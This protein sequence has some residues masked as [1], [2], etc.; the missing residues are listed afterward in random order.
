MG[1]SARSAGLMLV[2]ALLIQFAAC[3]DASSSGTQ[4]R[5]STGSEGQREEKFLSLFSI[6]RFPNTLCVASN[7]YNGTCLTTA[8][9]SAKGGTASGTCA[10]GFGVCCVL[11][12]QTC[13][14]TTSLNN[15]Y[16]QNNG[17]SS[18]YTTAGQCSLFVSRASSDVDQLRLEFLT[19]TLA[20]PDSATLSTTGQCITDSFTVSGAANIVPAIC[21]A[22][23][24]QHMYIN[25]GPGTSTVTLSIITS[26]TSTS[27]YWNIRVIQSSENDFMESIESLMQLG[28]DGNTRNKKGWNAL[29]LLCFYNSSQHLTAAIKLLIKS[30]I[31]KDAKEKDGWN[32][33]HLLCFNNSSPGLIEAINLLINP[34]NDINATT[35]GGSNA[36]HLL[37]YNNSSRNL[38]NAIKLLIE[39]GIDINAKK[40]DGC[41][42][43]HLLCYNNLSPG[44]ID[45]IK[46]LFDQGIDKNAKNGNGW[47]ALHILSFYNSSPHK[48]DAI[49]YFIELGIDV[50]V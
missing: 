25:I 24:N 27:R 22:N 1:L 18:A 9:C 14:A 12:I 49:K 26:G 13:G 29:H 8:E 50:I 47:N 40:N 2:I 10:S 3:A 23:S 19:F 46:L 17:F 45:A 4:I 30:G 41:N 31:D 43:L 32:A 36:L 6:V 35:N 5:N 37:C 44:L 7:S 38:I 28:I 42:A 34:D 16:W 15:T 39:I 21:G 20:Q 48:I 33:L 11:T